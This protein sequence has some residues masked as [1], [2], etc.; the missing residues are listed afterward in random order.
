MARH[1]TL[2]RIFPSE[3]FPCSLPPSA[4]QVIKREQNVATL[5]EIRGDAVDANFG[6][7]IRNYV[8]YPYK[9]VKDVRTGHETPATKDVLDGG[10]DGFIAAFLRDA[11]EK[12]EAEATAAGAEW[13][14]R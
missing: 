8:L 11:Y 14:E 5:K 3:G 13:A 6:M 7:Q 12:A 10:L 4:R 2:I 9:L 1:T